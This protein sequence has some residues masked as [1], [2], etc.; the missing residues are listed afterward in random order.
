MDLVVAT[1]YMK[2]YDPLTSLIQSSSYEPLYR[3]IEDLYKTATAAVDGVDPSKAN[4]TDVLNTL[5]DIQLD[6]DLYE[7]DRQYP[8]SDDPEYQLL[9]DEAEYDEML[10]PFA[11]SFILPG[12]SF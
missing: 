11:A 9:V 6:M 10:D 5:G 4:R 12:S 8:R 7:D 2:I 1:E 3:V